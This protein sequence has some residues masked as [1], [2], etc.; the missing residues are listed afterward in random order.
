MT[1]DPAAATFERVEA[2][3]ADQATARY[4]ELMYY[5][6][7][8]IALPDEELDEVVMLANRLGRPL[9]WRHFDLRT[10]EWREGR[11][12][13]AVVGQPAEPSALT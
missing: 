3:T 11:A 6:N 1:T 7:R 9:V 2:M 13:L 10:F 4:A 8:N 12:P 5:A